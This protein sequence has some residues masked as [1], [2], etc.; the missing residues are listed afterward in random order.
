VA[1]IYV[2]SRAA[3]RARISITSTISDFF[4]GQ[5]LDGQWSAFQP[6]LCRHVARRSTYRTSAICVRQGQRTMIALGVLDHELADAALFLFGHSAAEP[7]QPNETGM[8]EEDAADA[9]FWRGGSRTPRLDLSE[10]SYRLGV[11]V[12]R[13]TACGPMRLMIRRQ[14]CFVWS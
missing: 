13:H 9:R 14:T 3:A 5:P 4:F 7:E 11:P 2:A 1:A 8:V 10:Q 12:V 6:D